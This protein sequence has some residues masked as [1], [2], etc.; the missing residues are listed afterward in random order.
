MN[1]PRTKQDLF[2]AFRAR[3]Q[4]R[5]LAGRLFLVGGSVR[6]LLAKKPVRDVDLCFEGDAPALATELAPEIGA[7]PVL[8][9]KEFG[10][11]RLVRNTEHLDLSSM[12]PGGLPDDLKRRDFTINAMALPL[13]FGN[14]AE[15]VI[16]P[17]G[18]RRDLAD[19][20]IR[21]VRKSNL[22]QDPLR[23]LRAFRFE[24]TLDFRM[25]R[26]TR[27]SVQRLSPFIASVPG[28]RILPEL[29]MMFERKR[30]G[31][32]IDGLSETGLMTHLV[33]PGS[34]KGP[35]AVLALAGTAARHWRGQRRAARRMDDLFCGIET[36]YGD[37]PR[38]GDWMRCPSN[39]WILRLAWFARAVE[40]GKWK[41]SR[42]ADFRN[43][44]P[45]GSPFLP[46]K[47]GKKSILCRRLRLPRRETGR[48]ES[49]LRFSGRETGN[50]VRPV[51]ALELARALGDDL[52][53]WVLLRHALWAPATGTRRGKAALNR[54]LRPARQLLGMTRDRWLPLRYEEPLITGR[55]LNE[56]FGPAHAGFFG[57]IL[58]HVETARALGRIRDRREALARIRL[59]RKALPPPGV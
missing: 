26:D 58:E 31:P 11:V 53:G 37:D 33:A 47:D 2:N 20:R 38:L 57:R 44:T 48:V 32:A 28:E 45:K 14:P 5:G 55:D 59:W 18:G 43:P 17:C 46:C 35:G 36:P 42:D 6:D 34:R 16:D 22:R 9:K 10:T 25:S 4:L 54:F 8:L 29:R 56:L 24:A 13:P 15:E 41:N 50:F 1:D 19:R 40:P 21:A 23:L 39:R 7:R 52:Y 30:S 27:L 49:L 12:A 51:R 3:V